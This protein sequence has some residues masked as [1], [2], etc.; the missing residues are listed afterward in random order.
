MAVPSNFHCAAQSFTASQHQG[1]DASSSTDSSSLI[2]LNHWVIERRYNAFE[3]G[4]KGDDEVYLLHPP[5]L[6]PFANGRWMPLSTMT[7]GGEW[8]EAV[9][10]FDVETLEETAA[11]GHEDA[12][13]MVA[14][15]ECTEWTFS[16]VFHDA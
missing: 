5:V 16:I 2:E 9:E 14:G 3:S 10:E 6:M 4:A 15:C 11:A 13:T 7:D 12:L 8:D 1:N